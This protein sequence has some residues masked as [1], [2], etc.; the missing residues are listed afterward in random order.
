MA[1]N[2]TSANKKPQKK[3]PVK[4]NSANRRKSS[5]SPKSSSAVFIIIIMILLTVIIIMAIKQN[6]QKTNKFSISKFF[7]KEKQV[8]PKGEII[9]EEDTEHEQKEK[10]KEAEDETERKEE[11]KIKSEDAAKI[12]EDIPK[13]KEEIINAKIFFVKLNERTESLY[14][15]SVN[16]KVKEENKYAA[17]INELIKG[18]SAQEKSAGYLNAFTNK[19]KLN[20][21]QLKDRV[22]WCDFNSEIEKN[23]AGSI[24]RNRLDQLIYTATQFPEVDGIVLTV[25]GVRKSSIGNDGISISGVLKR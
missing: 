6:P 7:E 17:A 9:F 22:L 10:S 25:N 14:V 18:M 3:I 2:I 19:I 5:K 16:R 21:V 1:K 24:M 4:A 12:K 11:S 8:T 20:R 13:T 15:A 23:A